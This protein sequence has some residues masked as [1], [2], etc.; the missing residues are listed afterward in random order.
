MAPIKLPPTPASAY[1][2]NR[3]ANAL[4][5]AHVRELERA[6]RA[7]G[8][9]VVGGHPKTEGQVAAY[10]RQLNRALHNQVLLP[11]LKRRPLRPAADAGPAVATS[12]S[13]ARKPARPRATRKASRRAAPKR[14]RKQG[15]KPRRKQGRK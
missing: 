9:R 15:R 8:R 10:M 12:R 6:V 2:E 7:A 1:D 3:P 4:L 14:A 5:L 11:A 13:R